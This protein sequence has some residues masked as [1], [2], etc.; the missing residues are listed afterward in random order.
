MRLI[1]PIVLLLGLCIS[2]AANAQSVA[3]AC[4]VKELCAGVAPG[5]G[6][7]MDC[8][9]AHKSEL[10]QSCLVAIGMRV[11]NQPS[12]R[13]QGSPP[14]APGGGPGG[15]NDMGEPPGGAPPDQSQPPK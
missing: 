5:G 11:L 15:P 1:A 14:G 2:G 9:K 12:R 7:V 6:R 8:L 4:K 3:A 13:P 10:S